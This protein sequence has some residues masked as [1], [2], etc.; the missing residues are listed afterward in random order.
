MNRRKRL[1][2]FLLTAI[3]LSLGACGT[4][5]AA[6]AEDR[7]LLDLSGEYMPGGGDEIT[8]SEDF[9]GNHYGPADFAVDGD[10]V[11]LLDTAKRRVYAYENGTCRAVELSDYGVVGTKIAAADGTAYVLCTNAVVLVLPDGGEGTVTD[12][13]SVIHGKAVIDFNA[14][15]NALCISLSE[16]A[17]GATHKLVYEDGTFREEAAYFDFIY[18]AETVYKTKLVKNGGA[19]GHGCVLTVAN[20][21]GEILETIELAMTDWVYGADYLGKDADGR[22]R[23]MLFG[24]GDGED[25]PS[26][27]KNSIL[28]IGEDGS[29]LSQEPIPAHDL[30]RVVDGRVYQM[31]ADEGRITITEL[32]A[33]GAAEQ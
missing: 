30:I 18:D 11:Y 14:I 3:V 33:P 26:G 13:S 20:V 8:Y 31:T 16:G 6:P 10:A 29:I 19:F 12:I 1:C 23:V 32:A 9:E 24:F 7:V 15:G 5:R 21:D 27:G 17:D 4:D 28:L 25:G 2:L 22:S